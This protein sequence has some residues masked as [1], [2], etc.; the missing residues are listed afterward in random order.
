MDGA[1]KSFTLT[2]LRAGASGA[3]FLSE[4]VPLFSYQLIADGCGRELAFSS[5]FSFTLTRASATANGTEGF[6]FVI[7]FDSTPPA[8]AVAGGMGYAGM[9]ARSVAVEFDTWQDGGSSGSGGSGGTSRSRNNSGGSSG[10][11]PGGNHVGVNVNGSPLSIATATVPTP[12]NDGTPKYAWIYYDPSADAAAG[13]PAARAVTA[14]AAAAAAAGNLHL[15]LSS[16]PSP[17]PSKP[18]LS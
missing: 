8:E 9:A 5:S 18:V 11:E 1:T 13:A 7:A 4:R 6:A 14:A 12:L 15:F 17:R 10:G 3:V 2:P 16:R